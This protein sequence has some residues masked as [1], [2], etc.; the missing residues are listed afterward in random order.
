MLHCLL[1]YA[2]YYIPRSFLNPSD[3]LLVVLEEE[4]ATPK[5]IKIL[6]VN[7]D[8]I[9]SYITDSSPPHVKSW[10]MEES[11]IRAVV[12]VLQPS[13]QLKCPNH[14]KIISVDFASYGDPVGAC[15]NF[16]LGTC[17]SPSTK[18]IVEQVKTTKLP[19][20]FQVL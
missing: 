19:F 7:R 4:K 1:V 11:H 6:T 9:C 2:R 13:A 5:G 10:A 3:N 8:T 14:K 12:D 18:G 17:D 16:A 20:P 15:G